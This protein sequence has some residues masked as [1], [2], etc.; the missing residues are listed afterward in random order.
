MA[1]ESDIAASCGQVSQFGLR[2]SKELC[3]YADAISNVDGRIEDLAKDVELTSGVFQDAVLV[4]DNPETIDVRNTDAENTAKNLIDG[5]HG[6]LENIHAVLE[7]G[8]PERSA[9]PFGM[10]KF[11]ILNAELDLKNGGMQLLLLTIQVA[12]LI[13]A[14]DNSSSGKDVSIRKMEEL[15]SAL[16]ASSRR[17]EAVRTE[18]ILTGGSS[19][20]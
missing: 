8:Q 2:I 1:E 15:M 4:F 16:E 18:A 19:T 9:W 10:H 12:S 17:L 13:N 11:E 7:E 6:I 20:S 3:S 14:K 5:Y